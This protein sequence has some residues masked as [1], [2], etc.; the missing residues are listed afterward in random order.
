MPKHYV[1]RPVGRSELHALT[2]LA[3]AEETAFFRRNPHL[4]RPYRDRLIAVALCQGAA[5]QYL[6]RGYGVND[7]DVHFFYSQNPQ[8]RKLT[9]AK[10]RMHADVSRFKIVPVDF[11]RTVVPARV[12]VVRTAGRLAIL[13]AFLQQR[14]TP[15]ARHLAEK[16]VVGLIP[17]AMF[18]VIVWQ[19]ADAE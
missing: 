18:G 16:A 13:E 14:P 6:R 11:L 7:F 2:A 1:Q 10:K 15:N 9:R 8:K 12:K 4:V 19:P 3:K 17:K 5:L